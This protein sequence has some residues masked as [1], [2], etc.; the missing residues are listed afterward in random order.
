MINSPIASKT[1]TYCW[2]WQGQQVR[3]TYEVQ[4][5]GRTC[6]LLPAFST[7]CSRAEVAALAA[8]L[9]TQFQTITLD[10]PG[11]GDSDRPKLDYSPSLYHQFL[12]DFIRDCVPQPSILLAT[13]HSAGYALKAMETHGFAQLILVAPTWRGPLPTMVQ[14][15]KPWFAAIRGLVRTPILGQGLYQLNTTKGFLRMMYRRHVYAD[16]QKITPEL[17]DRKQ[18][19]AQQPGARY[20]PVAF[21]TGGLDPVID[22]ASFQKSWPSQPVLLIIGA[23]SPPKSLAEMQAM[24]T[25]P[26]TTTLTLPGTLGLH[27]EN[28]AAVAE[29]IL[30]HLTP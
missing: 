16:I 22:R 26:H 24:A 5:H 21:V 18:Q 13:G 23:D 15:Q 8:Q 27:E 17:I 2:S 28:A 4:G 11:F 25:L 1:H 12:Q 9:A 30:H 20:A 10:W 29:A 14:G 7:V 3:I 19:I 6:L